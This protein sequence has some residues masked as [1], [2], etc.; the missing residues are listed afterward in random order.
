MTLTRPG[1]ME[2]A[3]SKVAAKA[4]SRYSGPT[5]GVP[6]CRMLPSTMPAMPLMN[7]E[8]TKAPMM[9]LETR[10]PVSSAALTLEP[11]T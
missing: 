10:M 2:V 4:G 11:M 1:R 6:V 7:P 8:A 3:P 9:W 5:L